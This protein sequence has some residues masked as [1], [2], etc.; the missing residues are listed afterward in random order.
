MRN[1]HR[2]I[3]EL[4]R[5][6]LGTHRGSVRPKQ[7]DYRAVGD[8]R[9]PDQETNVQSGRIRTLIPVESG[10]S[11]SSSIRRWRQ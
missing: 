10:H 8:R 2:V 4:K 3:S 5:W 1:V 9:K 7:L 6:P 11:L